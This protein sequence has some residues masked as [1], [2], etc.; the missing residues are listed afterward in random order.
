MKCI[1]GS[2]KAKNKTVQRIAAGLIAA[3]MVASPLG[4]Q[5]AGSAGRVMTLDDVVRTALERNREMDA[6]RLETA[7][8]NQ[9]VREAWGS[10]YPSVNAVSSF[11]R[12]LEVPT[13]FLPAQIFDPQA[14]PGTLVPVRLG[15]DNQ[16]HG[17][18]RAEQTLFEA[19]VFIGVGAANR[20]QSLK[21]EELRGTAQ[22]V[23]TRARQAYYDVLLAEEGY[24]LN[25][26]AVE[27]VRQTLEE[28]R[29][30][31]RAG[32]ASE[33]DVLRLEVQLGNLEP[34]LRQ[35]QNTVATARRALA[36]ELGREGGDEVRVAGSLAAVR[37]D[38][39]ENDPANRQIIAFAGLASPES[40][41]VE[42]VLETAWQRR[43][44]LRQLAL[45]RSLRHAQLRAEQGDYLP[46]VSLFGVYSITAQENGSPQFFGGPDAARIYG[47]QV[48][49][50]V[51]MPLFSGFQRS[52]RVQQ[53]QTA[54]RQVEVQ[55]RLARV[56]I[57]NQIRTLRDNVSEARE[58]T[59]AQRRAVAQ[60]QRGYEIARRQYREGISSQLEVSD[61][62]G[63]LRESEF[64]Y[65][66]AV[67]DYLVARARLDEAVG[68]VPWV[69]SEAAHAG[70]RSVR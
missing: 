36:A 38:A 55:Q 31:Q 35:S 60:A 61:A 34:R 4:A 14:E 18:L 47:Q 27:R 42:E 21:I 7:D 57:E 48:G 70:G 11:T 33:Y 62:E 6:A 50:Q 12:N 39:E 52:A 24:R 25:E 8:A 43:S 5:D 22:Q 9:R 67:H 58:R 63:A 1:M 53:R 45:T 28:T 16:W 32:L 56:Q 3:A 37:L 26:N 23:A 30:R 20:F 54:V 15:F 59:E 46:R 44:D 69:D 49:V 66:E 17:Q 19:G 51:T 13:Q 40:M 2:A 65:A 68:V 29:A 64:N 10:V 41:P